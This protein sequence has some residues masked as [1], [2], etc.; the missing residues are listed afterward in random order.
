MKQ[1]DAATWQTIER[2]RR[3]YERGM[4]DRDTLAM[5]IAD[6]LMVQEGWGFDHATE[7]ARD[8][9]DGWDHEANEEADR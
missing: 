5:T 8:T 1:P 3:R 2:L 9:I 7:W 4:C 6:T